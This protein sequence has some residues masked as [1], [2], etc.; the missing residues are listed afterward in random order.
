M[1]V[2][3][4]RQ[5]DCDELLELREAT[6]CVSGPAEATALSEFFA[7]CAREMEENPRW[8]HVHFSGGDI[9]DVIV[10]KLTK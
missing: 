9:P 5:S 2:F 3:G 6:V 8:D 10:A 4:Y 1:K 7:R